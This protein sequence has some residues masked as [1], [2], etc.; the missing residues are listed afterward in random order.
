[1]IITKQAESQLNPPPPFFRE[2]G[3]GYTTTRGL[4]G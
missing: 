4:Q 2:K 1:M 3:K